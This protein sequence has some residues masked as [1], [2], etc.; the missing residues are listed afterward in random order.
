MPFIVF[1]EGSESGDVIMRDAVR[2]VRPGFGLAPKNLAGLLGRI[3]N[4]DVSSTT[5]TRWQLIKEEKE[6]KQEK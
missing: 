5:P 4:S 2:S 3:V 1:C 6:L